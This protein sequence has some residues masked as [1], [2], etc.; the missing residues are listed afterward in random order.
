MH[1]ND[2]QAFADLYDRYKMSVYHYCLKVLADP[3]AAED[4]TH[5]T[6]L[7]MFSHAGT[8]QNPQ[9]LRVWLL[10]TARNEAMMCFRRQK[11]NIRCGDDDVWTEQ[12]PHDLTVSTETTEI[13]QTLLG[14]LKTE[15][16]EVLVLQHYEQ[17]SYAEIASITGDSESS[18]KSRLYKARK[19]LMEKMKLYDI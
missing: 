14:Q 10:S 2:R 11:R 15:Y 13:V 1:L 19:A 8:L 3:A 17:L 7:K 18:V 6:F 5:E 4:A 16:R 9:A 12:T